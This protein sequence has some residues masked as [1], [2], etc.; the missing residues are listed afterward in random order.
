MLVDYVHEWRTGQGTNSR[1]VTFCTDKG[2]SGNLPLQ[3]TFFG[4][5]MTG[6]ACV[7]NPVVDDSSQIAPYPTWFPRPEGGVGVVQY[8]YQ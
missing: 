6:Y 4:N 2:L 8:Q 1:Y 7:A 5:P 3:M